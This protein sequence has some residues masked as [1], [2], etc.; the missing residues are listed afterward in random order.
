VSI[1]RTP[2]GLLGFLGIKNSGQYPQRLTGELVPTWDL[3][4]LY[5]NASAQYAQI[6]TT[7]TGT[8]YLPLFAAPNGETWWITDY[9]ADVATGA[10]E[11]W[12]GTLSRATPNNA[13]QVRLRDERSLAASQWLCMAAPINQPL[14][15]SPGETV[16]TLTNAVVGTIDVV[17]QI[18][19]V[20]LSS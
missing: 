2:L 16:G 1:N 6:V 17:S 15:L 11:T 3:A 7:I 8:G 5:L 20:V 13:S 12:Q 10:A 18:R 4:Q 19:Y 9:S 14:I